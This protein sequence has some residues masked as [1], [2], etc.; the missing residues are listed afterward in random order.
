M[1]APQVLVTQTPAVNTRR[2]PGNSSKGLP[3][4]QRPQRARGLFSADK[5]APGDDESFEPRS[6]RRRVIETPLLLR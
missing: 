3:A 1:G 4:T 5:L 2:F 6:S